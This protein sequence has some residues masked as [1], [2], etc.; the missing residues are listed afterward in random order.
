MPPFLRGG[1]G[2]G[3]G[4]PPHPTK[5]MQRRL[6]LRFSKLVTRM[7]LMNASYQVFWLE[8]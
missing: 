1:G 5:W 4:A 3:G 6:G 8:N 7:K 2:G